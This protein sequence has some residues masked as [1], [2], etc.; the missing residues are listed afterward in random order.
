VPLQVVEQELAESQVYAP[1]PQDVAVL[2]TQLPAP[3]QNSV[4]LNFPALQ[5]AAPHTVPVPGGEPHTA[6]LVPSHF[7]WQLPVP[8]HV[9]RVP[10]GRL[11]A[12]T[13]QH[14]PTCPDTL[15]AAQVSVQSVLQQTPSTHLPDA[16]S[17]PG[18]E[19]EAP[20]GN[21]QVPRPLALH[22]F[23]DAHD[24]VVQHA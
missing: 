10:M 5:V 20:S 17:E 6:V 22:V 13:G 18:G 3:S 9:V 21:E 8:G 1:L 4:P 24:D 12:A 16:Q 19:Q 2:V 15:Q 7:A 11:P 14:T 23:G